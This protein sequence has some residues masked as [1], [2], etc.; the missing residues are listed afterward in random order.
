MSRF[1]KKAQ[2]QDFLIAVYD[3][4]DPRGHGI[5]LLLADYVDICRDH[6][7]NPD[8]MMD[9][10]IEVLDAPDECPEDML[11]T[12]PGAKIISI[13]ELNDFA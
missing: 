9:T 6:G 12:N 8:Q 2:L 11:T 7:I 4:T 5:H 1:S 10:A 3:W 13:E